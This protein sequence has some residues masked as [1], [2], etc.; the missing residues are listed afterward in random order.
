MNSIEQHL[1][2]IEN[3]T[4]KRNFSTIMANTRKFLEQNISTS[5]QNAFENDNYD[6]QTYTF[7][8][9]LD[10]VPANYKADFIYVILLD[11]LLHSE[12]KLYDLP[13]S[14]SKIKP[15]KKGY[16]AVFEV[17]MTTNQ[18]IQTLPDELQEFFISRNKERAKRKEEKMKQ[19]L[20]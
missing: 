7:E 16:T 1:Q 10:T 5:N 4:D 8:L 17:N 14:V 11:T 20:K 18:L 3:E 6:G 12:I 2:A 15:S 9:A 19:R 13:V